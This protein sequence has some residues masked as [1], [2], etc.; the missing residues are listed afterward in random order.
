MVQTSREV[1]VCSKYHRQQGTCEE[2]GKAICLVCHRSTKNTQGKV[3]I[4]T[5]QKLD[6]A[7][8]SVLMRQKPMNPRVA[9]PGGAGR[10]CSC[11][12]R[13]P[14]EAITWVDRKG[15]VMV[16][17]AMTCEATRCGGT[18]LLLGLVKARRC[19]KS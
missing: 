6:I 8:S 19:G 10:R 5:R 4:L 11:E 13:G 7:I 3:M 17:G 2:F 15:Q 14:G 16:E 12:L 18:G 9:S 1:T